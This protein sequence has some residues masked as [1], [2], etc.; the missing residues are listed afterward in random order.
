MTL[1]GAAFLTA[2]LTLGIGYDQV[3]AW[4]NRRNR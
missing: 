3:R 4:A 1:L 2:C